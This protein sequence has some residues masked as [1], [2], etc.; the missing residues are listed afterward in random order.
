MEDDWRRISGENRIDSPPTLQTSQNFSLDVNS[1]KNEIEAF[2]Y[3]FW[4]E[5]LVINAHE[6]DYQTVWASRCQEAVAFWCL[7]WP[8]VRTPGGRT[9]G[10]S[11]F[12]DFSPSSDFLRQFLLNASRAPVNIKMT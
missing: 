10:S 4:D 1:L 8:D 7:L 3:R 11:D 9:S 2:I 5:N 12:S 6:A